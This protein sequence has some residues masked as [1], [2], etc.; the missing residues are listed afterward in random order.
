MNENITKTLVKTIINGFTLDN[1]V[2]TPKTIEVDG[3]IA[4]E[5][6]DAYVRKNI[7]A[8]LVSGVEYAKTRY[9]LDKVTA[10]SEATEERENKDDIQIGETST[11]VY[12]FKLDMQQDESGDT[13]PTT[14]KDSV[15][16]DGAM[17]PARA[18]GAAR[19]T[20]EFDILPYASEQVRAKS[21]ISRAKFFELATVCDNA[22]VADDEIDD[23]I[24]A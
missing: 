15:T 16:L 18:F 6:V 20:C 22:N 4:S 5:R 11:V 24:D 14:V 12:F 19:R 17:L 2:P 21:F 8:M 9:Q 3:R 10:L 7:G 1:G 13:Y 23:E